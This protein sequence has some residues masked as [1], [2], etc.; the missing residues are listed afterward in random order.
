MGE[1]DELIRQ[2]RR[3]MRLAI[4]RALKVAPGN[5]LNESILHEHLNGG[6]LRFKATRDQ[7]K[8]EMAWLD[9]E[10]LAQLEGFESDYLVL[11]LREA[12]AD[13]VGGISSHHGVKS[14]S[15]E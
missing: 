8:T 4:L 14:P 2:W 12:G 6:K 9:K 11:T 1:M 10:S 7:V 3:H 15:L 13:I 5:S